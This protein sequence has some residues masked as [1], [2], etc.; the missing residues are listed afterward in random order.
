MI[1]NPHRLTIC[2]TP[3]IIDASSKPISI[4]LSMVSDARSVTHHAL[5]QHEPKAVVLVD[6]KASGETSLESTLRYLMERQP[7]WGEPVTEGVPGIKVWTERDGV[8]SVQCRVQSI[9]DRA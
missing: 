5:E 8:W 1:A 2:S 9:E 3:A 6:G 4:V 7:G